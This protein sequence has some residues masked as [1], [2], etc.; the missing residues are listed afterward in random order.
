MKIEQRR[1][2][3]SSLL[4]PELAL[5]TGTFGATAGEVNQ[6][7]AVRMVH[8]ALDHGLTLIDTA[9][10]YGDKVAEEYTG[11][12]LAT[13][14]R[15]SYLITTK[16]CLAWHGNDALR[17]CSRAGVLHSFEASLRRLQ[18][19]RVD[20]LHLHDPI[21]ENYR[22]LVTE[23]YPTLLELRRQGSVQALSVGTGSLSILEQLA[24]DL[25]LD[26]VMIAGR[27]TLLD[28]T[29]L[30]L[31]EELARRGIGVLSAGMFNS[32]ILATGA[33][34]NASYDYHDAPLEVVA[35]VQ[36]L[37]AVCAAYRVPLKVAAAQFIK[38]HP[39]ITTIVIGARSVAQLHENIALFDYPISPDF[40]RALRSRNLID[41]RAP[42]PSDRQ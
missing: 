23:T 41:P 33:V 34:E 2:G 7:E 21:A 18:V 11:L 31:L 42:L 35:R 30:N 14:P 1:L 37:E 27:Y 22:Q 4:V 5:G 26:C 3:R 6:T 13:R 10:W 28:Q 39:A 36:Q 17:D 9:P 32:G 15:A 16:V 29:A 12:A 8:H 25:E 38:A 40:W 20:I 19:D 24:R